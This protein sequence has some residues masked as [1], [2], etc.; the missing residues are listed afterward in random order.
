MRNFKE[1]G[2]K[3]FEKGD[4]TRR[5]LI[6]GATLA[7]LMILGINVLGHWDQTHKAGAAADQVLRIPGRC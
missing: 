2:M 1:M 7:I 6:L 5:G 4:G 3:N